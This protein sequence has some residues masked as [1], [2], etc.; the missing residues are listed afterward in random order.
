MERDETD[1]RIAGPWSVSRK[2]VATK[3]HKVHEKSP[4][5]LRFLCLFAAMRFLESL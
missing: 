5:F 4:E 2:Y 3:R 1:S